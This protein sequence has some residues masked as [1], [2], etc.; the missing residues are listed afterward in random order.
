MRCRSCQESRR[1]INHRQMVPAK[2]QVKVRA[3]SLNS[4][5]KNLPC[6]CLITAKQ[7]ARSWLSRPFHIPSTCRP[8]QDFTEQQC[9]RTVCRAHCWD[10]PVEFWAECSQAPGAEETSECRSR[11]NTIPTTNWRINNTEKIFC[12]MSRVTLERSTNSVSVHAPTLNFVT[13][14]N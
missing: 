11:S 7:R 3:S 4:H 1:L 10:V 8:S 13:S 2:L 6:R 9:A 5:W 14:V 12:L